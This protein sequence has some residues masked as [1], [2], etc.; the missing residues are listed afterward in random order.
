MRPLWSHLRNR[1]SEDGRVALVTLLSAEGSTPREAGARMIVTPNGDILGTI[2]GGTLEYRVIAE[3][4]K[5]LRNDAWRAV[6]QDVPL[7]PDLGQCCGGRLTYMIETFGQSDVGHIQGLAQREVQDAFST[8]G[9]VGQASH[10]QR[11]IIESALGHEPITV[12]DDVVLERFRDQRTPVLLFGAGHVGRAL[13]LALV[14]LPFHVRWIDSRDDAFPALVPHNVTVVRGADMDA[15][16]RS[17]PADAFVIVM[18]HSHPLDLAIVASALKRD[19]L[20]FVG[21]IGSDTK[22]A[23]FMKRLA[24][25]GLGDAAATRLVSPIGIAA[26]SGKEPAV[27]AASI[28]ADLLI[29]REASM[30]RADQKSRGIDLFSSIEFGTH[31]HE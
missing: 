22:R 15:E 30:M 1:I 16:I 3:A 23:R 27:I 10:L 14:P 20:S 6:S 11:D 31:P 28:V 19:D 29:R 13:T 21:L 12:D 9:K 5:A 24:D 8:R 17:A 26:I 18:T 7:G 2:G 25:M 4:Q